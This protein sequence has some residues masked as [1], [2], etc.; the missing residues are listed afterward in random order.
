[1]RFR[2]DKMLLYIA[3]ADAYGMAAEYLKLPRERSVKERCLTFEAYVRHPRHQEHA[4]AYTDDTEMSIAN[5]NVLLEHE[6]PF[7]Q[8]QFADAY[9]KEFA[10]GGRRKGYSR[11]FQALLEEV[12]SGQELLHRLRPDSDKNG[13]AMRSATLGVVEDIP[14]MLETATLQAAITHDTPVGRFSARAVALMSHYALFDDR[15]LEDIR[16]YCMAELPQVD[17]DFLY[18]FHQPWLG[19]PVT[20]GKL[21]PVGL[22]TVQAVAHL[23]S[24]EGSLMDMLKRAIEWGGD[25]DSVAAIAWGIASARHQDEPLPEFFHKDLERHRS[26]IHRERLTQ[27]GT[28]LMDKYV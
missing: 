17:R 13:A 6:P 22:T 27:I 10:F 28:A 21:G 14:L 20:G 7:S 26:T 5:A 1:M 11:G 19:K 24:H 9:V 12:T 18:V 3:M 4:G 16:E 23:V 25:V 2:N 15:P 8:I